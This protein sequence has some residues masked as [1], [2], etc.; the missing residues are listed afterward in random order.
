[1]QEPQ[2]P[3]EEEAP[4]IE[5]PEM[6]E[7]SFYEL[8]EDSE[9]DIVS[10][11]IEEKYGFTPSDDYVIDLISFVRDMLRGRTDAA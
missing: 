8:S 4:P 11:G 2:E 9:I 3:M 6:E 1:M 7:F 5:E 10:A